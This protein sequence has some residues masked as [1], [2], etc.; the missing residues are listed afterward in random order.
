[1]RELNAHELATVSGGKI[2]EVG[3]CSASSL[4]SR[5]G[6]ILDV[7]LYDLSNIWPSPGPAPDPW[8]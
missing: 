2:P 5:L 1:M 6:H 4:G 8:R 3:K 7:F